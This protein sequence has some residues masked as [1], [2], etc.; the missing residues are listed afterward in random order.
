MTLDSVELGGA[1]VEQLR[2][3]L[4]ESIPLGLLGRT[5]FNHFT[6]QIDPAEG[7]I[8]L[9][10]NAQMRGG[11][12]HEEWRSRFDELRGEIAASRRISGR[13]ARRGPRRARKRAARVAAELEALEQEANAAG[14]PQAWRE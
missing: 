11:A 4:S 13:R 5:F 3:S 9:L 8:T 6:M 2:G 12:T 7:V 14:V 10:P 1:R